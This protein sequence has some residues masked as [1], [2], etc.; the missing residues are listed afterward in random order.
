MV[1]RHLHHTLGGREGGRDSCS[2]YAEEDTKVQKVSTTCS[3]LE[4]ACAPFVHQHPRLGSVGGTLPSSG[5]G[6]L[7]A[8]TPSSYDTPQVPWR[9]CPPGWLDALLWCFSDCFYPQPSGSTGPACG[10]ALWPP[11]GL[12]LW[13]PEAQLE[14]PN[15]ADTSLCPSPTSSPRIYQHLSLVGFIKYL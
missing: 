6:L 13:G 10:L 2:H 9:S 14:K 5:A 3:G 8:H 12:L 11:Y 7:P 1:S 15:G 4:H